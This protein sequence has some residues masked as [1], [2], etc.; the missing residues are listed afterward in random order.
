M[1]KN[2]SPIC[3]TFRVVSRNLFYA[4]IERRFKRLDGY[5]SIKTT[6]LVNETN[7]PEK[8]KEIIKENGYITCWCDFCLD[9]VT[10]YMKFLEEQNSDMNWVN[11]KIGEYFELDKWQEIL[12]KGIK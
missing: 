4:D 2:L 3:G 11:K 1:R 10:I 7:D 5:M 9:K 12:M 6:K 8:H